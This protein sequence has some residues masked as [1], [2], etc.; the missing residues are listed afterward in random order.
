MCVSVI[1]QKDKLDV[2]NKCTVFGAYAILENHSKFEDQSFWTS[3]LL[4]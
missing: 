1:S 2:L 4:A 3:T